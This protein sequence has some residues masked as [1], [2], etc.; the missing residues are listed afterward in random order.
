MA[1][2]VLSCFS[3]PGSLPSFCLPYLGPLLSA[4]RMRFRRSRASTSHAR[5][6][7]SAGACRCSQP[8]PPGCTPAGSRERVRRRSQAGGGGEHL[9]TG[10]RDGHVLVW[11]PP[12]GLHAG[13][14]SDGERD[15]AV[16]A[17]GDA[18]SD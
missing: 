16:D 17:E 12:P 9:L 5:A 4:S 15:G 13:D 8:V 11:S 14:D 10:G 2:S 6:E 3:S 1:A 7:L 18:W